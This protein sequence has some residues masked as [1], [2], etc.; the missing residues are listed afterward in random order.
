LWNYNKSFNLT[1]PLT[2][3][4][5]NPTLFM[6]KQ[7]EIRFKVSERRMKELKEEAKNLSVPL[8]SLVKMKIG[9]DKNALQSK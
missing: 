4:S 7:K 9:V 5:F 6:E 8:A 2:Y 1:N 3:K